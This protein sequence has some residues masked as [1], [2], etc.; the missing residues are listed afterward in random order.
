MKLLAG[1]SNPP[2]ARSIA[3]YLEVPLTEASVSSLFD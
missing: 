1:N 3:D 2:L